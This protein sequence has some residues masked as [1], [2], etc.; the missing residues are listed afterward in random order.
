MLDPAE[1]ALVVKALTDGLGTG[2]HLS[3]KCA[4]RLLGC[5]ELPGITITGIRAAVIECARRTN[6]SVVKKRP[7]YAQDFR[8]YY[9]VI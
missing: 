8:F 6:G 1:H 5:R 2:V 9:K 7:E 4:D 3:E